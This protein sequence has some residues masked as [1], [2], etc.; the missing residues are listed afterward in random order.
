MYA[1]S[2]RIKSD[3][4]QVL[5]IKKPPQQYYHRINSILLIQDVA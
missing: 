4:G 3:L 1:K 5:V 2:K